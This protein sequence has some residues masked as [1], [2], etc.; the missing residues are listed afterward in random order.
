MNKRYD[1]SVLGVMVIDDNQYMLQIVKTILNGMLIK[2]VHG[3]TNAADAFA[4]LEHWHPDI[5]FVDWMMD[6]INGLEFVQII[7]QS[8]SPV[9]FVPLILL[10]G[11]ADRHMVRRARDKGADYTLS[12]PVSLNAFHRTFMR[13]IER[14]RHFVQ[15]PSYFGPNR[16]FRTLPYDGPERRINP[17]PV[18][19]GEY[20]LPIAGYTKP[21]ND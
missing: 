16:R 8:D 4:D 2:D 21:G 20:R 9:R 15:T 19:A 11:H 5:I 17:D 10:T 12:K 18:H 1:F 3:F 6:P 13:L 14:P 7:R